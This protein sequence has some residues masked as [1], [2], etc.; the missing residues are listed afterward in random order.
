MLANTVEVLGY[1]PVVGSITGGCRMAFGGS[2]AAVSALYFA[3]LGPFQTREQRDQNLEYV[4]YG[5]KQF[6]AGLIDFIPFAKLMIKC[7]Q[8]CN[9]SENRWS[10]SVI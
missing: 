7:S 1:I 6:C 5:G 3:L 10:F 4:G 9:H 2:V 8:C